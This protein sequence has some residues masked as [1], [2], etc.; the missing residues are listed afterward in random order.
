MGG[1]N[2]VNTLT[3]EIGGGCMTP[4]DPMVAATVTKATE[5]PKQDRYCGG[6]RL[7]CFSLAT[8]K[9]FTSFLIESLNCS[10]LMQTLNR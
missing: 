5:D 3:F 7:R 4:P 2:T 10:A 9:L 6:C 8:F 1:V